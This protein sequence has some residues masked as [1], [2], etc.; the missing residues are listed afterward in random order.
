MRFTFEW[1]DQRKQIALPVWVGLIQSIE[2]L[3]TTKRIRMGGS[4][5]L[6]DLSQN[7]SLFLP[8]GLNW[9]INSS[10]ASSLLAFRL[11]LTLLAFL[12]L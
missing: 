8:S 11:E 2:G 9:T 5:H 7:I 12:G 3:N 10:W 1:V 6:A 4:S